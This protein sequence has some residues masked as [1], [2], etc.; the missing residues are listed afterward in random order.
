MVS[1]NVWLLNKT[2]KAKCFLGFVYMLKLLNIRCH[3]IINNIVR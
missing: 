2:P 1:V 3:T